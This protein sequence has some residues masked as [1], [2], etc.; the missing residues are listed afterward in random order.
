MCLWK[1]RLEG[2]REGL[3]TLER[4]SELALSGGLCDHHP[5]DS[6]QGFEGVGEAELG[7]SQWGGM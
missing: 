5:P 4:Q 6:D 3:R 2:M 7:G 1:R